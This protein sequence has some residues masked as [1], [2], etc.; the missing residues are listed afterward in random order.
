MPEF[1]KPQPSLDFSESGLRQSP[2]APYLPG[3]GRCGI[4]QTSTPDCAGRR[5]PWT[6]SVA[7]KE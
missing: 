2:G 3:F 1:R 6:R 4:P 7:G 5:W